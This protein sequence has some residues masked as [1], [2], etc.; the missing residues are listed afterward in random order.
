[1]SNALPILL[2]ESGAASRPTEA[3]K[4]GVLTTTLCGIGISVLLIWLI[5]GLISRRKFRLP[6][7][8]GRPNS[9]NPAH[10]L[11]VFIFA[12]LGYNLA[13]AVASNWYSGKSPELI[14]IPGLGQFMLGLLA[15]LMIAHYFFN[16]GVV[17]GMGLTSRRWLN[18]S[19]RGVIAFLAV[20][21]ICIA[22]LATAEWA[23]R[24][25]ASDPEALLRIHH[26]LGALKSRDV[27]GWLKFLAVFSA[28]V[29]A[30][31]G[32]EVFFRGLLQ[33]MFRKYLRSPWAAI[34]VTSLF[35][36]AAH[37][38]IPVSLPALFVLSL[39]LGYCYE[40]TGRLFAPIMIHVLFNAIG[41]I[42]ALGQAGG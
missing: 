23:I 28:V 17:R 13:G 7:C 19:V 25:L 34:V 2:A 3:F 36:S 10:V 26:L 38:A 1:M 18:D 16:G 42:E 39:A 22:L 8:P 9:L 32:E 35:F 37:V 21:P 40:R 41:I 20:W 29:A 15:G 4:A 33:S 12:A 27:P 30:P 5:R 31:L 11:A 14:V 24:H 6:V